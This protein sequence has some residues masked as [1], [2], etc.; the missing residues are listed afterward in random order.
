MFRN[1]ISLELLNKK[2]AINSLAHMDVEFTEIGDDYLC[3]KMPVNQNSHQPMGIL[4]GG[5][6]VFLAES[7]ASVA[8]N[9]FLDLE[10]QYCVGL[11]INANHIRAMKTGFLYAKA[12]PI[13]LGRTTQVWAI[14]MTNEEG[15]MVCISRLTMAVITK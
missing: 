14:D 6:S 9:F 12:K 8:G 11:S 4:H 10:K 2:M 7:V 1:N 5:M 13:H 3:A 15:K